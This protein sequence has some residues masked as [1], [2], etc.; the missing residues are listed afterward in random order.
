MNT[1]A[2]VL[3][4]MPLMLSLYVLDRLTALTYHKSYDIVWYFDDDFDSFLV[5]GELALHGLLEFGLT[6]YYFVKKSFDL[7]ND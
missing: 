1:T 5:V 2:P 3:W 4:L 6:V 7:R